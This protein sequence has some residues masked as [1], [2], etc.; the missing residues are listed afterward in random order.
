[1][2]SGKLLAE[3]DAHAAKYK[4]TDLQTEEQVAELIGILSANYGQMSKPSKNKVIAFLRALGKSLG[5][6]RMEELTKSE[7]D[8][9]DLLNTLSSRLAAGIELQAED[10]SLLE[11][12]DN[13]TNP[14]G[15][16]TEI[17]LPKTRESRLEFKDSYEN[18]LVTPEKQFDITSL[19]KDIVAKK[20]KVWFWVAD[21]LGINETIDGGPSFAHQVEGD[22]WASSVSTKTIEKNSKEADYLF[23]ISG[24]PEVSKLFNK[25]VYDVMTSKL[26]DFN[27]SLSSLLA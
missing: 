7:E 16:P 2:A 15:T 18:S 13:G 3:L 8:V 10:V 20:Q 24:S 12:L 1:M 23:I 11:E 22:I 21:Q 26:G 4:D 19:I 14:I 17:V 5:I 27:T 9:V 6:P 25:K